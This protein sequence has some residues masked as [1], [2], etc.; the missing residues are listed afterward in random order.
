MCPSRRSLVG[1]ALPATRS[2]PRWP[3]TGRP[4]TSV[5]HAVRW[6]NAFEPQIRALLKE[7][8]KMPAPEAALAWAG[9][10]LHKR[11]SAVSPDL[12]AALY[13][14]AR[15]LDDHAR[16]ELLPEA[17]QIASALAGGA[18]P[19]SALRRAGRQ[20]RSLR[21]AILILQ[22][23]QH[24]L[25]TSAGV[26]EQ[27]AGWPVTLLDLTCRVFDVGGRHDKMV[28]ARCFLQAVMPQV[29]RR[30]VVWRDVSRTAGFGCLRARPAAR[31]GSQTAVVGS[32]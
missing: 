15:D 7:W 17:H 12:L 20:A 31:R 25:V 8:P 13:Q 26:R 9:K 16:F 28:A 1:S 4:S 21:P 14:G 5:L 6:P 18:L 3:L 24:L 27:S 19:A 10:L 2:G 32:R 23:H 29:L 30:A 11:A 22:L